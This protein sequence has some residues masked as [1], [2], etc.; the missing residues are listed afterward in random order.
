MNFFQKIFSTTTP[1]E[2]RTAGPD[3]VQ[4]IKEN[5]DKLWQYLD[6]TLDF[7]NSLACPCA[8]PRFRQIVGLDCVDFR[9]SFYASETEGFIS[10]A[11][12]HFQIQEISGG[13]ENSNQLWTCNTC[14]STFHCGWSDFSIH[15]NR[16]FLKTLE[17]K[18][19][20]IGADATLPIPLFVG[21]FGHTFPDQSS[22]LPVDYGTFTT[23]IRA[24][25]SDV[26]I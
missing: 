5:T 23:Y 24:L 4:M 8:F 16:T 12:K 21:L 18:T 17:L 26:A 22:I 9:K 14:A 19:T 15:V 2:N 6:E 11:G 13:D 20:D 10:L 25:K 1:T 3:R 7:Y